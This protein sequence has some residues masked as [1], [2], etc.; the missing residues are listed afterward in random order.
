MGLS[1]LGTQRLPV[2]ADGDLHGRLPERRAA[3][4]EGLGVRLLIQPIANPAMTSFLPV[5][6]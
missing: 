4:G 6:H 1:T 2:Q 3:D 5:H